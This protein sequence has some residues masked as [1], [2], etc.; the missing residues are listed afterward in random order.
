MQSIGSATATAWTVAETW[1]HKD[2]NHSAKTSQLGTRNTDGN[3][4]DTTWYNACILVV[5]SPPQLN[6]S[7]W[8]KPI[9][10][11]SDMSCWCLAVCTAPVEA[12]AVKSEIINLGHHRM[13]MTYNW[14]SLLQSYAVYSIM[15]SNSDDIDDIIIILILIVI[16]G[17]IL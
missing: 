7:Q 8:T 4:H 17:L 10:Q 1:L 16:R 15:I 11:H 6:T 5:L 3:K 9:K 13:R 2:G 12:K 14:R